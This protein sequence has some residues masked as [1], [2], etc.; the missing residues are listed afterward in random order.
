MP[1][2]IVSL[3]LKYRQQILLFFAGEVHKLK[4]HHT[5]DFGST[6][7]MC[8]HDNLLLTSGYDLDHGIGYINGK[9]ATLRLILHN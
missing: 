9:H 7:A 1:F 2:I 4:N 8:C 6:D 3:Q 5:G